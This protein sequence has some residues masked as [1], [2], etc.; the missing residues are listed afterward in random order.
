[1]VE[2]QVLS[3]PTLHHGVI[4]NLQTGLALV[5]WLICVASHERDGALELFEASS[6]LGQRRG[7]YINSRVGLELAEVAEPQALFRRLGCLGKHLAKLH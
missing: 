6:Q 3:K 5:D 4:R 1:M 2:S 7:R